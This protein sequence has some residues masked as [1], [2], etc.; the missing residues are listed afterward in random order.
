MFI[1][2]P[3][4]LVTLGQPRRVRFP[5]EVHLR[6]DE[7]LSDPPQVMWAKRAFVFGLGF[8]DG[9]C[10]FFFAPLQCFLL[11]T[12][13]NVSSITARWCLVNLWCVCCVASSMITAPKVSPLR[14]CVRA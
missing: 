6:R 8:S 13:A 9:F 3:Y 10:R 12:R 4:A 14:H 7:R 2:Y 11:I 5:E 1:L